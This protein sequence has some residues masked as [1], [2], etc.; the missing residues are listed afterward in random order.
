MSSINT[1]ACLIPTATSRSQFVSAAS[2]RLMVQISSFGFGEKQ[3]A[4]KDLCKS[5]RLRL[6]QAPAPDKSSTC[7]WMSLSCDPK[8]LRFNRVKR[9]GTIEV[10]GLKV[11][12]WT[13]SKKNKLN[14]RHRRDLCWLNVNI[15]PVYVPMLARNVWLY[16]GGIYCG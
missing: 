11:R 13:W 14:C 1:D 5:C 3:N 4:R 12:G 7:V 15:L 6:W 2:F 16:I 8:T 10:Y 9:G